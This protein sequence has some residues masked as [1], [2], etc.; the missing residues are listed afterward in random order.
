MS[1]K[2]YMHRRIKASFVRRG[3]GGPFGSM[4]FKSDRL[5][6]I[7]WITAGHEDVAGGPIRASGYY[8][9]PY[10][11]PMCCRPKGPYRTTK[12][13]LRALAREYGKAP[14]HPHPALDRKQPTRWDYTSYAAML[15]H[16]KLRRRDKGVIT[17]PSL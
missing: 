4:L 11:D 1:I 2:W 15:L 13:A 6:W 8:V 3:L 14:R 16:R 7:R 12:L 5:G 9:D 10:C 17:R